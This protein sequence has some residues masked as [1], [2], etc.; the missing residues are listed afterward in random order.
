MDTTPRQSTSGFSNP[1]STRTS[2]DTSAHPRSSVQVPRRNRVALRDYYGLKNAPVTE[3]SSRSSSVDPGSRDAG[4]SLDVREE[5]QRDRSESRGGGG[6]RLRAL[7]APTFDAGAHIKTVLENESLGGLLALENELLGTIKT[8][9]GERKALVYDNYSKLITATDTIKK[10][11]TISLL[12]LNLLTAL[13]ANTYGSSN[14]RNSYTRSHHLT[15]RQ[16]GHR[17]CRS[18]RQLHYR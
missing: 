16:N 1:P 5:R 7:D 8:L 14:P 11:C 10:V 4:A 18:T 13:D 15:H 3:Q 17:A 2:L 6:G 9:D 12:H